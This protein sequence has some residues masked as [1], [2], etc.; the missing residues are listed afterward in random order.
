M[1]AFEYSRKLAKVTD[2]TI[3]SV[4]VVA[5]REN[6]SIVVSDAIATNIEGET[7]AGNAIADFPPFKD[8]EETGE[9]HR[10]LGFESSGIG[11]TSRGDGADAIFG[12]YPF[13]DTAAPTGKILSNEAKKDIKVSFIERIL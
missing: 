4:G 2:N 10:N 1:N 11:F 5:V 9:F 8:W 7:F 13:K 6:E 12:T 3:R